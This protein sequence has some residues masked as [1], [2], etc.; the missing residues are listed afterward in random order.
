MDQIVRIQLAQIKQAPPQAL[1]KKQRTQELKQAQ[2][3]VKQ[4]QDQYQQKERDYQALRA[5]TIKVIQGTSHLNVDLL[6]SLISET[7]AQLESLKTQM[8]AAE[9]ELQ[10]NTT[11]SDL[12]NQE[13][14][15]LMDW[16][17]LYDNCSIE[18]KKMI[19]SQFVKA[20]H[21][22]RGYELDIEFNVSFEEFQT[23]YLEPDADAHKRK[24]ATDILALVGSDDK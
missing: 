12:V 20:V 17:D 3:K 2:A 16:A 22:K 13:Y 21:V 14:T 24:G 19:L 9:M 18:A 7:E 5:E 11:E 10:R 8:Q 6:N 15:Q 23:M 1:L 4:L